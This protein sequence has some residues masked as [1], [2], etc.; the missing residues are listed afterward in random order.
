MYEECEV[1]FLYVGKATCSFG[2][3]CLHYCVFICMSQ[4]M[5]VCMFY[6]DEGDRVVTKETHMFVGDQMNNSFITIRQRE[7]SALSPQGVSGN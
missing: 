6:G 4:L 2:L 1:E 5:C 7:F 3:Y